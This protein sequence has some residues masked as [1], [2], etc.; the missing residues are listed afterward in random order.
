M[1]MGDW[2]SD[3]CSSD[4]LI[5][6]LYHRAFEYILHLGVIPF[7]FVE[8]MGNRGTVTWTVS[9]KIN[10]FSMISKRKDGYQ[11]RHD[12]LHGRLRKDPAQI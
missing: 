5:D 2:S 4:L 12:M 6:N 9:F 7:S 8:K 3:V 11:Y 1:R 10:G